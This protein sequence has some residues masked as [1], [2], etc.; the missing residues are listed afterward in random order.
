MASIDTQSERITS[1]V[2]LIIRDAQLS[3][4][5]LRRWPR[6]KAGPPGSSRASR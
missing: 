1:D 4:P 3:A 6:V 2:R 5:R